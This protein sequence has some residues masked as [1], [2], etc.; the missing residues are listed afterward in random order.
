VVFILAIALSLPYIW[1]GKLTK[2]T[3]LDSGK[4]KVQLLQNN[5]FRLQTGLP[6][7]GTGG[8]ATDTNDPALTWIKFDDKAERK[9][10]RLSQTQ[11]ENLE[12]LRSSKERNEDLLWTRKDGNLYSNYIRVFRANDS[13]ISCHYP[14]GSGQAFGRNEAIGAAIIQRRASDINKTRL[15]N[16][17]WVT[18]TGLIGGTGAVVA[19][20]VITQRVILRPVRQLRAMANNVADGN[21]DIRSSIKTGD[22]F[23]K[24]SNA[25][26]HMLD[27]VQEGQQKLRQANEQ[28]DTKIAELSERNIELL[29]AN[30][31]KGEFLANI[32]HD[33]RT[34]LNAILGFAQILREKPEI[35]E[36][37]K[38]R[39]YAE[40]II[41]G[42]KRLLSMINDLLDLA[43][44]EAG[45]MQLH[46]EKVSLTEVCQKLVSSFSLLTKD[47][48]IKVKLVIEDN[49][50]ELTTDAGKV[51]QILH[52]FLSNAV[53]FTDPKGRVR[54]HAQMTDERHVRISISDTGCGI[55]A[56][57]QQKIFEKFR[58]VDGS[59]TGKSSGSG[60][61][62]AISKE[63][64]SM[65]A[66]SIGLESKEQ[67]GSTFWLEIPVSLSKEQQEQQQA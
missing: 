50:P 5:H 32:S 20:Y 41:T 25:F 1:M 8:E 38:G 35:L 36:Q 9:L 7:L 67:K 31:L 56:D 53:K 33:F 62:L 2:K 46:I 52:N 64:A 39:K 45:K 54:I 6:R 26:N 51:Q 22:E 29:K 43:K 47:K 48:R 19:F 55:A 40:N 27:E 18:I 13:C 34:P 37:K 21:L 63:L 61:G 57:D 11:R 66:G 30:K 23:E 17:V 28:L 60:L 65:L 3:F 12:K 58:R 15:M 16:I 4:A 44:T 14:Q 42:G 24:M 10:K 49:I 59:L